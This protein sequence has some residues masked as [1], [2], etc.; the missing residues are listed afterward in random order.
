MWVDVC[1]TGVSFGYIKHINSSFSST[2]TLF[3]P[4]GEYQSINKAL[5]KALENL[6]LIEHK[7]KKNAQEY[8]R[9]QRGILTNKEF[10][11]EIKVNIY[12]KRNNRY[13]ALEKALQKL[14]NK[15]QENYFRRSLL[16]DFIVDIKQTITSLMYEEE[17]KKLTK[18]TIIVVD[19]LAAFYV[20][21]A[22]DKVVGFIALK[23]T[24]FNSSIICQEKNIP[25][26]VAKKLLKNDD[27]VIMDGYQSKLY[28]NPQEELI[29]NYQELKRLDHEK[30]LQ[31]KLYL[32]VGTTRLAPKIVDSIKGIGLFR[33]E[34]ACLKEDDIFRKEKQVVCYEKILKTLTPKIVKIALFD[35]SQ[36]KKPPFLQNSKQTC[37][38]FYGPLHKIYREQLEAILRAH[39]NYQNAEI[40][41]PQISDVKE[42]YH[43]KDYLNYLQGEHQL[44]K[45]IKVGIILETK[46]AFDNLLSY[47][48]VDSIYL[49]IDSLIKELLNCEDI[50]LANYLDFSE[51][52]VKKV[53]KFTKDRGID[54]LI[55][56]DFNDYYDNYPTIKE[57]Y[58]KRLSVYQD[59]LTRLITEKR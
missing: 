13:K 3:N 53:S 12:E 36:D 43:V 31:E 22:T 20:L 42:Y 46:V 45:P 11:E 57:K 50:D 28:I 47:Q 37:F 2:N 27:F 19:E 33:S 56:G 35:F 30:L 48:K 21:K 38:Q 39:D 54:Y 17:V 15:L 55:G 14:Q 5:N 49:N 32:N 10:N 41:I 4:D 24:N 23:E 26:F 51:V 6:F 34:L 8:L 58:H 25:F 40:L 59:F 9:S 18:E 29:K 7:L 16:T 44:L 1:S 52:V